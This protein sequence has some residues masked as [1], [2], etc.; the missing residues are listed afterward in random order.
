MKKI[1]PYVFAVIMLLSAVG[2]L[3]TPESYAPMIPEF[4]PENVANILAAIVEGVVGLALVVPKYRATG[5]LCFSLLMIAFLPIH[6]WDLF[7]EN[8]AIGPQP[9]PTIRLI[10]QFLFIYGGWWLFKKH[11]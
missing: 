2:H 11:K 8:P 9:A 4:I 1:L 7:K 6:I 10:I 5:A 3:V